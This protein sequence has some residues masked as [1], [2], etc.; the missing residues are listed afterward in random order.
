[1]SHSLDEVSEQE[2]EA[3]LARRRKER[4]AGRCDYCG[5]DNTVPPC[6]F[7]ERHACTFIDDE[8][9]PKKDC[10]SCRRLG[11]IKNCST[12]RGTGKVIDELGAIF[13][14]NLTAIFGSRTSEF[15][16]LTRT[17]LRELWDAGRRGAKLPNV[18]AEP[19]KQDAARQHVDGSMMT[20][21]HDSVGLINPSR[22][23][24]AR[25]TPSG[26]PHI[27]RHGPIDFGL[28]HGPIDFGQISASSLGVDVTVNITRPPELAV[29]YSFEV[30]KHRSSP[31]EELTLALPAARDEDSST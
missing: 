16:T 30:L 4:L 31:A 26:W 10:W 6:K 29:Q 23:S 9:A 12:C 5:G 7:P 15:S 22:P 21:I 11:R 18:F 8:K 14:V 20:F 17:K 27:N 3:E 13:T 2:L 1:M 24:L 25:I 19:S 28:G